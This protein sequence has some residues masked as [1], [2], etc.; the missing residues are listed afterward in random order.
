MREY[1]DK[2]MEIGGIY[3]MGYSDKNKAMRDMKSRLK[4]EP[5]YYDGL[6]FDIEKVKTED[7]YKC[8]RKNCGTYVFGGRDCPSCDGYCNGKKLK[9]PA[10]CLYA[11]DY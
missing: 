9:L 4:F 2:I 11:T 10:Y 3:A 1:I 8:R 6:E 7:V 5:Y